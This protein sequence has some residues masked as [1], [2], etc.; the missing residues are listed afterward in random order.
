MT[1]VFA[2][3]GPIDPPPRRATSE[4]ETLVAP[5]TSDVRVAA[6]ASAGRPATMVRVNA[7]A[8]AAAA[9]V[10]RLGGREFAT[11]PAAGLMA[12]IFNFGRPVAKPTA[13]FDRNK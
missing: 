1:I 5:L 2:S 12:L 6:E 3:S 4:L 8:A 13:S 11:R 7:T 9:S 10:G